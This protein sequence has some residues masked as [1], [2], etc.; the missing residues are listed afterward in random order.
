MPQ[1][2]IVR[3]NTDQAPPVSQRAIEIFGAEGIAELFAG[4][5]AYAQELVKAEA[6]AAR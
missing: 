2:A 6:E 3:P 5:H 4:A 1:E